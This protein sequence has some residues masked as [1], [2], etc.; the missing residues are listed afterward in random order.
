[1]TAMKMLQLD[2]PVSNSYG[3]KD[4]ALG[5]WKEKHEKNRYELAS[6]EEISNYINQEIERLGEVEIVDIRTDFV[7]VSG[8]NNGGANTVMEYVTVLYK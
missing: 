3:T 5:A 1:M 7:V 4:I 6:S 8:H 2:F